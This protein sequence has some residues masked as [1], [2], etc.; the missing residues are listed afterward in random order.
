[1]IQHNYPNGEFPL[2]LFIHRG[3]NLYFTPSLNARWNEMVRLSLAKYGVRLY[4][5]GD[6]DGLGGWNVYR[7]RPA[8]RR[9][10]AHYGNMAAVEGTSSHGGVYR[11][12][13]T[14]ALDISNYLDLA[15]GNKSLAQARLTALAKL[16]G[17]TVNFVT[18]TEWWHVG[19]F[20]NAWVA[21]TFG[22]VT[23]NPGTTNKPKPTDASEEEDDE[24][25]GAYFTR[26]GQTIYALFNEVSGFYVE[27]Q[28]TNPD[29]NNAIALKWK[30]GSFAHLT[31]SVA[32]A[33]KREL[34]NVRQGK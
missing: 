18:P 21:P 14:F 8:Q 3:G 12:K 33:L 5:T 15:P 2:S 4:I 11:G 25:K 34:A 1:M 27:Y 6:V 29:N 16:V 28:G 20:N 9:Y 19:D 22:Q 32:G 31:E 30:T 23:V 26:N 24:M 13:Q 17:L 10:R 7:N